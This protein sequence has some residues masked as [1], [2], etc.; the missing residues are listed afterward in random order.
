MENFHGEVL[1]IL[2]DDEGG[3]QPQTLLELN[4]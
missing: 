2:L 3:I 4:A 1:N